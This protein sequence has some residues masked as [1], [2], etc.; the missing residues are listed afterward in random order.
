MNEATRCPGS[1]AHS[2]VLGG[3]CAVTQ[4]LGSAWM[5]VQNRGISPPG[6]WETMG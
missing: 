1:G 4:K 3:G 5:N 6:L 2:E